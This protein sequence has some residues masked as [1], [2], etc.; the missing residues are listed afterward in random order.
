M[1]IF[2]W[3]GWCLLVAACAAPIALSLTSLPAQAADG[4]TVDFSPTAA[5]LG[6]YLMVAIEGLAGLAIGWALRW[7]HLSGN[8]QAEQVAAQARALLHGA[9]ENG[10]SR[11]LAAVGGSINSVD[12]HNQVMAS[13]LGYAQTNAASALDRLGA[14]PGELSKLIEAKLGQRSEAATFIRA[15]P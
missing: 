4:T 1:K 9:V 5:L 10:I 14:S 15:S 3:F 6:Q 8:A 11:A 7:L 13:V 12:V 2:R